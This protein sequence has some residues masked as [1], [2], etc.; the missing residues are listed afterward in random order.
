V[1]EHGESKG[2]CDKLLGGSQLTRLIARRM[3]AYAV[4]VIVA[5][6]STSVALSFFRPRNFTYLEYL[7]HPFLRLYL[8]CLFEA[9]VAAALLVGCLQL[10]RSIF[11]FKS[12]WTWAGAGAFF[13]LGIVWG[14]AGLGRKLLGVD[15]TSLNLWLFVAVGGPQFLVQIGALWVSAPVGAA[16]A[17]AL[18]FLDRTPA[19]ST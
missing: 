12:L 19:P 17:V 5:G 8:L 16:T 2:I 9:G 14:M 3:L 6:S 7:R 18:Y 13:A 4:A 11:G 1:G 15:F 10:T